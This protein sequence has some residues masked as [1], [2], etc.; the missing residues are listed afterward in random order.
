[1]VVKKRDI[2]RA[3]R[4]VLDRR[5]RR[6]DAVLVPLEIYKAI[7]ALVS[8]ADVARSNPA[9]VVAPAALRE[10]GE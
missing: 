7:T 10:L 9:L 4:V 3:V 1:V 2:R 5:N 6:R 8:S